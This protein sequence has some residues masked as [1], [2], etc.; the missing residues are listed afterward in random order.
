M[1]GTEL[2]NS[3][4]LPTARGVSYEMNKAFAI[5]ADGAV[6]EEE[7]ASNN[8]PFK[9]RNNIWVPKVDEV[10]TFFVGSCQL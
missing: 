6:E 5:L 2:A 7:L 1:S 3:P 10:R 8:L 4:L 9:A